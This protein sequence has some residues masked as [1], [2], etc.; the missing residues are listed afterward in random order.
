LRQAV[1]HAIPAIAV[2]ADH[3]AKV[4][5]ETTR[6]QVAYLRKPVKTAELFAL[7]HKVIAD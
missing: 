4:Q 7:I 5:A 3:T 6:H 1:G 2:T